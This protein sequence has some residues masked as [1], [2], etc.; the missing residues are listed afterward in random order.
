MTPREQ[1][2]AEA[3]QRILITDGAFGTEIQG[4][5]LSEADYAAW[6]QKKKSEAPAA[7]DKKT[8]ALATEQVAQAGTTVQK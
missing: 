7:G 8:A 5:K 2:L 3:A 6:V 1:F 4:W